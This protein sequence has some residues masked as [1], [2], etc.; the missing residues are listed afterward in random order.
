MNPQKHDYRRLF[1]QGA[2][3]CFLAVVWLALSLRAIVQDNPLEGAG[4]AL[5]SIT[6]ALAVL[7]VVSPERPPAMQRRLFISAMTLVP[8]TLVLFA[9][10]LFL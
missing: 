2:F 4:W 8:I 5:L 1:R 9:A 10:S 7:L 3:L 6:T